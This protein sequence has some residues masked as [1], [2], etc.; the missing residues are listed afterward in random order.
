MVGSYFTN[1]NPNQQR[2]V[3]FSVPHLGIVFNDGVNCVSFLPPLSSFLETGSPV[4]QAG[5]KLTCS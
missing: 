5:T 3:A 4:A 1:P 2:C